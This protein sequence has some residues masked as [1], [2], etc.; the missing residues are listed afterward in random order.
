MP[1][2]PS[3]LKSQIGTITLSGKIKTFYNDNGIKSI[4]L[5]LISGTVTYCG[6]IDIVTDDN[7][8]IASSAQTLGTTGFQFSAP[9]PV[10]GLIIDASS[11]VV[12][13]SFI[14]G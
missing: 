8:A 7:T 1:T 9:N 10:D 12:E 13:I 6:S 14:Q 2:D 4:A 5:R 11:G 3:A